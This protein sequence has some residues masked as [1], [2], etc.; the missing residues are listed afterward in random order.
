GG[1]E[2]GV[3][4]R[5]AL[6]IRSRAAGAST[7]D[8]WKGKPDA[9]SATGCEGADGGAGGTSG[10][11]ENGVAL[12]GALGI[13]SR[14]G[15][16]SGRGDWKGKPDA[17]SADG[18]DDAGGG[19]DPSGAPK[20]GADG[21]TLGKR[22]RVGGGA[23]FG[24]VVW[25]GKPE[26]T[27]GTVEAEIG[28]GD[29][30]GALVGANGVP[31]TNADETLARRSRNEGASPRGAEVW[32]GNADEELIAA[33]RCR[34]VAASSGA[35]AT[36]RN[37][38]AGSAPEGVSG[39]RVFPGREVRTSDCGICVPGSLRAWAVGFGRTWAWTAVTSSSSARKFNFVDEL[40]RGVG[41]ASSSTSSVGDGFS[42]PKFC[43]TIGS[44]LPGFDGGTGRR[45]RNDSAAFGSFCSGRVGS[46]SSNGSR[47]EESH[48]CGPG[49]EPRL[50]GT[51]FVMTDGFVMA[52]WF[53]D[54]VAGALA[55]PC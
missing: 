19:G 49:V 26:P 52:G 45:G 35:C 24:G 47:F 6:G 7:D 18:C 31:V 41:V 34:A 50:A 43:G 38:S 51:E 46:S 28:A 23:S 29:D 9:P 39:M 17:L 14:V 37:G 33:K 27:M 32:N 36:G 48:R 40:F 55:T 10:G 53:V 16:A 44:V 5:G 3:A 25:K 8:V 13:R 15:D 1:A 21:G 2:N 22:S 4:L 42:W 30:P 11:A 12:R 20:I 54:D